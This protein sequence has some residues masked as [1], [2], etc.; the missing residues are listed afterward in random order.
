MN[1]RLYKGWVE[2]RRG[3][4]GEHHFRYRMFM[5]YVDLAE[6]PRLFDGVPFW[7]AHRPALAWFKRADYLGPAHLSLD[8]AVRSLVHARTGTR[9]QGPIRLLTHL[10]Y[11]GYC[12]NPVSFYYC[13]NPAGDVLETIVAEITNTPWGERHQ[14]VLRVAPGA[15][16]LK[17]FE[18]DKQFHV[19]PFLPPDMRYHWDLSEPGRRLFVNMQNYREGARVFAATLSLREL[20]LGPGSLLGVLAA[21][22]FLTLRILGGIYFQALRLYLK[23]T[24]VFAHPNASRAKTAGMR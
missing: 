12:M 2:H 14:Y 19:S 9:P 17:H 5:L 4:P 1:S 13:F 11:F 10:R 7:S 8:A 6:L 18:F 23:R 20:P 22:P 21:F 3:A 16:R 24:P 15:A